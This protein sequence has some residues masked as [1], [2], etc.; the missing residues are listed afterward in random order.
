[1]M[2]IALVS[3]EFP[4]RLDGIGDHSWRLAA[5]LAERCPVEVFTRTGDHSA[6]PGVRVIPFFD[7][8]NPRSF[9]NLPS[10]L[11]TAGFF[12]EGPGSRWVVLQYNPFSWGARGW[13]PW[14]PRTLA[15]LGRLPGAPRVAIIFHETMVPRWPWKFAVM[16]SWQR[17]AFRALCR[18]ADAAFV[19]SE[20]Y[21]RQAEAAGVRP[22]VV[23]LPIGSNV[24]A[25]SAS[26]AEARR[27]LGLA[28]GAFIVG[29][30]GSAH[31]S[32]RLDWIGAAF[33][34][35][36][37]VRE[38]AV[39]LYIGPHGETLRGFLG[40]GEMLDLGVLSAKRAGLGI[41]AMDVMLAP[42]DDGI[43]TRRGSVSA[44]F[45]N[46]V[47]VATT[48]SR[49]SDRLFDELSAG[50]LLRSAAT[51]SE[52]F[53]DDVVRWVKDSREERSAEIAG[54]YA[55]HFDWPETARRLTAALD[56]EGR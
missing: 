2:R 44:A 47:P 48:V 6:V 3:A 37:E 32:R 42:F 16:R 34:R 18:L 20:R 14:V 54:F 19:S 55:R 15:E 46:G 4:P 53:A 43:S 7:P 52:G 13:C 24:D 36:G 5:A 41:R 28:A 30:F 26:R 35:L 56:G 51:S 50:A 9:A 31:V 21:G 38:D 10:A 12:D 23:H 22:P 11:R 25:A 39:L 17:P 27:G 40:T 45:Q 33:E 8:A 1:M 49:W 29:V